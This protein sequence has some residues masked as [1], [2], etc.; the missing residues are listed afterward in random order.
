MSIK[1][2]VGILLIQVTVITVLMLIY[3]TP[4]TITLVNA[5]DGISSGVVI[6]RV[7]LSFDTWYILVNG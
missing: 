5:D 6:D 3:K 4:Q 1:L 2:I 7:N